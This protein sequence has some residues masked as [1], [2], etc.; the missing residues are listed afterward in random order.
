[1][2]LT[3]YAGGNTRLI[4]K[5][6][7]E[8]QKQEQ[9]QNKASIYAGSLNLPDPIDEKKKKAMKEAWE[10]VSD[11]WESDIA[12]DKTIDERRQIYNNMKEIEKEATE[13]LNRL[14]SQENAFMESYD[15]EA[16]SKEQA[17]LELLKKQQDIK[18]HVSS[19]SLTPEE[20]ERIKN[21]DLNNLT[22]YQ[23]RALEL[24]DMGAVY[25]DALKDAKIKMQ[26]AVSDI[27]SIQLERLKSHPMVDATKQA[28][29]IKAAA[30]DE[31]IG[32]IIEDAKE[33]TDEKIEEAEEEA[34]K[35]AE[36]KKEAED[37]LDEIKEERAI[38]EA[39]ITG[40]REAVEKA[41]R[42]KRENDTPDIETDDMLELTKS[43]NI[44]N[45]VKQS[46]EEIKNSMNLLEADLKGIKVDET[47]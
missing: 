12:I 33:N 17:D 32:Q 16:D 30:S 26:D 28:E 36:E 41:E 40:T 18:N 43:S 6:E 20:I 23:Q 2:G 47:V 39:V 19:E 44:N 7:D 42:I 13:A 37:K 10:V 25:K 14:K 15:V 11:A 4:N 38:Q 9:K 8:N 34:E 21:I 22:E 31:I 35:K 24:N 45:D 5:I 46:L 29:A 3:I 1:M 27:N